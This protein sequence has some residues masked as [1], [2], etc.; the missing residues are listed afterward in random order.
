MLH[1]TDE[2]KRAILSDAKVYLDD[3]GEFTP[4]AW[5]ALTDDQRFRWVA[6]SWLAEREAQAKAEIE[7]LI[8]SIV[9]LKGSKDPK[10]RAVLDTLDAVLEES[11]STSG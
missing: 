4:E 2:Q 3:D 9:V 6:P 10:L 7:G 8:D 11:R 1:M 5:F